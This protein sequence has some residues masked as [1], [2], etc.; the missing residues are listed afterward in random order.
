K[1][2]ASHAKRLP[3]LIIS[4]GLIPTLAFYKAKGKDRGQIYQDISEILENLKC[5]P[6]CDWKSRNPNKE[7]IEFLLETDAH[8]LRLATTETLSISDW[9]KRMAEIELEK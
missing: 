7:L 3:Q 2:Y 9:L 1:D 8:T 6:F 5:K 4:N